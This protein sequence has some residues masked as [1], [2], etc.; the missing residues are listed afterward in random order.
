MV[1]PED[2]DTIMPA[3]PVAEKKLPDRE[4]KTTCHRVKT[5]FQAPQ[6]SAAAAPALEGSVPAEGEMTP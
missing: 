5:W 4:R 1:I 6:L 3:L 2:A